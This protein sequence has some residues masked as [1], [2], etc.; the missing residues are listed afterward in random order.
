MDEEQN[1]N[2]EQDFM[3]DSNL[4]DDLSKG[5]NDINNI[6]QQSKKV[7]ND[8]ETAGNAINN[9]GKIG[10]SLVNNRIPNLK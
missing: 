1:K 3:N 7:K 6:R 10:K 8:I 9:V 5:I 2:E 4:Q